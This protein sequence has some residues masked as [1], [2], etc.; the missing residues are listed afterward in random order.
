VNPHPIDLFH[1]YGWKGSDQ[2]F[3]TSASSAEDGMQIAKDYLGAYQRMT[4]EN[5]R[6]HRIV[7]DS[8]HV[9]NDGFLCEDHPTEAWK[10][11]GCE[12]AGMPCPICRPNL[13]PDDDESQ[14]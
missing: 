6:E 11:E 2:Y 7:W 4:L 12:A 9:C 10:H 5:V 14:E 1:V 8:A 3:V 13:A